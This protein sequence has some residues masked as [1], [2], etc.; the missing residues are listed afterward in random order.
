MLFKN[1]KTKFKAIDSQ[2]KRIDDNDVYHGVVAV[3]CGQDSSA[4]Q[5]HA[6]ICDIEVILINPTEAVNS[7]HNRIGELKS[8]NY[9]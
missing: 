6:F 8:E 9:L 3:N 5:Y 2:G 4:V 1:I 7:C